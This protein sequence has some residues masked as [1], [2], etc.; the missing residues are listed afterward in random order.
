MEEN[1]EFLYRWEIYEFPD[2]IYISS[3]KFVMYLWL[4]YRLISKIEVWIVAP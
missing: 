1:L 4:S 3:T 2:F